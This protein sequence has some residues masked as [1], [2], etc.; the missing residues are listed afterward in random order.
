MFDITSREKPVQSRVVTFDAGTI[1]SRRIED[2][3]FLVMNESMPTYYSLPAEDL[4]PKMMDTEI[5]KKETPVL[6]CSRIHFFP[7]TSDLGFLIVASIPLG[8]AGESQEVKREM[9]MG[10][11][12]T[13]YSSLNNLF[14]AAQKNIYNE[15]VR[16]EIWAPPVTETQTVIHRFSLDDGAVEYKGTGEVPGTIL[17]QFSMDENDGHFRIATTKGDV[18]DTAHPSKNNLYIL[19]LEDM[20]VKGKIEGI[21]PGE[22]IYSVRFMGDRAYMVTF[23]KVDP[24]FVIDVKD[25]ENP[26]ILG[27]L[28]IPGF[29]DYLHPYDENHIIGIGKD[30]VT[31]QEDSSWPGEEFNFAWYQGMKLALF[32]VTDVANPKQQFVELIGDRGTDSELLYNH[33]ALLFDKS[34]NLLAFPVTVMEIPDKEN[35]EYTG[36]EYGEWKFQGAYVYNLNLENGF[37]LKGKIT[38]IDTAEKY[39]SEDYYW[40]DDEDTIKRILYI[41]ENYYTVSPGKVKATDM[42]TFQPKNSVTLERGE[43]DYYYDDL[44]VLQ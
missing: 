12:N 40:F 9:F 32:D 16:Y 37:Q 24:F 20:K 21:A 27:A 14:V 25:P 34:K 33:K 6:P 19:G 3:L 18:W 7:G 1:S 22:R 38:H 23:K 43:D 41:G 42:E 26:K 10:W 11:G 39:G 29:S 15:N 8:E 13:V 4:L 5:S 36:S 35:R 17:N 44:E 31:P 28:K 30:T 2:R